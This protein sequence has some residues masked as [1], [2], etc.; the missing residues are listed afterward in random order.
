MKIAVMGAGGIGCYLGALLARSGQDVMLIC[1]G[2]HLDAI[3]ANGV[4]VISPSG[5]FTIKSVDATDDPDTVGPVDVV[6]Q[7]VKLYDLAATSRRMIPMVGA[8]TMIVPVQNGVTAHE[9][10]GAIAGREHVVG[11]SV[12]L[13]S[14]VIA[15]GVVQRKSPSQEL[16]FG[17]LDGRISERAAA[18]R[19]VGLAAGYTARASANIVGELWNKFVMLGAAASVGCLARQPVGR[20][21]QDPSLLALFMQSMNEVIAVAMAKGVALDPDV[22]EKTLEFARKV[23][24]ETKVSMLEDLEANKPLELEWV[25][26]HISREGKRHGIPTPFHD[27][28]YACLKPFTDGSS[29]RRR[30]SQ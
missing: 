12:F 25:S 27:I 14:F 16:V 9:E 18:F 20:I 26:G 15:P 29:E 3:R 4:R 13:A 21:M 1:R 24:Y 8:R 5:E 19:D 7:C 22:V 30:N 11:G 17:E 6:L 10:I 28:A 2:A 23:K